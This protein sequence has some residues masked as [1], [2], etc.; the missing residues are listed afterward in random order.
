[1]AFLMPLLLFLEFKLDMAYLLRLCNK[2]TSPFQ[3]D[4][5]QLLLFHTLT[6][7]IFVA[8]WVFAFIHQYYTID[9]CGPFWDATSSFVNLTATEYFSTRIDAVGGVG[10]AV[11]NFVFDYA[12]SNS[13]ALWVLVLVLAYA[14]VD[15]NHR[16]DALQEYAQEQKLTTAAERQVL[17][18]K[19]Q[20][21]ERQVDKLKLAR[22]AESGMKAA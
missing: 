18:G 7:L 21:L 20:K 2:T 12:V 19:V 5:S 6:M 13:Y 22:D 9:N 4:L 8:A 1:M 11:L 16:I 10:G 14:A 15:R 17:Q 3:G